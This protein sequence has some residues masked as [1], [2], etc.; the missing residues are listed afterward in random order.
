MTV[1]LLRS[2]I[3][4]SAFAFAEQSN[5]L[6]CKHRAAF[7]DRAAPYTPVTHLQSSYKPVNL[8]TYTISSLFSL[9][10]EPALYLLSP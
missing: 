4:I 2:L 7:Y 10:V 8:T 5:L 1:A 3:R 6:I 9:Q